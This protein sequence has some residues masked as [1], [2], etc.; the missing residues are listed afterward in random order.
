MK[1]NEIDTAK[2]RFG[3]LDNVP[4][5]LFVIKEDFIALHWNFQMEEWTGISRD[6]ILGRNLT[7]KFPHLNQPKYLNRIKIIFQGGPPAIFSSLLHQYIIPS[8]LSDGRFRTQDT[9]IIT[10][11]AQVMN[12]FYALFIIQDVTELTNRINGY[13]EMRDQARLEVVK[14]EKAEEEL[15]KYSHNLE[16]MVEE[17]T[18]ELN[19]ALND[20]QETQSKL[21]QSEKMASI[22]QL[23]AGVAHEINNPTGFISSNLTSLA[24]YISDT[25]ALCVQ[26]RD[27]VSDL[28]ENNPIEECRNSIS[29]KLN[30]IDALEREV[31]IDFILDD[32][33]ALV[34]ECR[35]GTERIKKIVNDLKNFAHPGNDKLQLADINQSI[36]ST[37]NIVWNELK[38]KTTVTKDYG[39]LPKVQCYPQ[40]LNQVFMNLLVNAAQ[41]IEKQGEIRIETRH[42]DGFVEI[43]ISDTGVGITD[44]DL[45]KVFDPFF[46]TKEVGKGTGLG[47]NVSY[48]IVHK[49]NGTIDVKSKVGEGTTFRIRIPGETMGHP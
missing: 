2:E 44:E 40:Q 49:H 6:K 25:N 27:L 45:A 28:K 7:D 29:E 48:N 12:K 14:R 41:A 30:R 23:A 46:T 16:E 31:D 24:E 9:M 37:L 13:K 43:N 10:L 20:L 33:P 39:D 38:Y 18:A 4:L 32:S 19:R 3:I 15:K 17:R 35:E 36:D 47:L 21:F 11:P 26:Y 8:P 34:K 22:G 42:M 1:T 5:G